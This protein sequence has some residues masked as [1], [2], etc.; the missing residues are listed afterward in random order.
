MHASNRI[1]LNHLDR[2]TDSTGVMQHADAGYPEA[3][4]VAHAAGV[5]LPSIPDTSV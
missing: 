2:M 3:I 5:D 1:P 4:R